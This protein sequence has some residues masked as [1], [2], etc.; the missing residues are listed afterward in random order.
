MF[1]YTSMYLIS[2]IFNIVHIMALFSTINVDQRFPFRLSSQVN[3]DKRRDDTKKLSSH[4]LNKNRQNGIGRI[5][6]P[7]RFCFVTSMMN[8][9]VWEGIQQKL[10]KNV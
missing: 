6:K 5:G 2:R 9:G 4:R 7:G 8:E 10:T 1:I 3:V